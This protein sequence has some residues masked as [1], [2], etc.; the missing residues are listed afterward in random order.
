MRRDNALLATC[1]VEFAQAF[2]LEAD[3]H[4]YL[5]YSVSLRGSNQL[6]H[7]LVYQ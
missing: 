6:D 7:W 2:M 5:L 1:L 3:Y 4:E